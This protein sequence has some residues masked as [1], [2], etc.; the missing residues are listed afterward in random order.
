MLTFIHKFSNAL[1]DTVPNAGIPFPLSLPYP[2]TD[3]RISLY[4]NTRSNQLYYSQRTFSLVSVKP[5]TELRVITEIL[6]NTHIYQQLD[7][8]RILIFY[9]RLKS[10]T[11]LYVGLGPGN[12]FHAS[13]LI[14]TTP[15]LAADLRT[16][17]YRVLDLATLYLTS[18][19]LYPV[20][21]LGWKLSIFLTS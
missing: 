4:C 21:F 16:A 9:C 8:F 17:S 11:H 18:D 10:V 14:E 5:I 3:I 6:Y 12:T 20:Y 2:F 19:F 7:T 15:V 13:S 1:V